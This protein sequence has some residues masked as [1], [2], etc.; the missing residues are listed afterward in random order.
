MF[1][2]SFQVLCLQVLRQNVP[3][4]KGECWHFLFDYS[5]FGKPEFRKVM[6]VGGPGVPFLSN[7]ATQAWPGA[8]MCPRSGPK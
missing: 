1:R 6:I 2:F 3:T 7:F 4:G 5:V 8:S